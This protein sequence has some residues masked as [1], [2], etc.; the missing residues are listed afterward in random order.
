MSMFEEPAQ[1][2]IAEPQRL[3]KAAARTLVVAKIDES[4]GLAIDRIRPIR[5]VQR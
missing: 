4:T 5:I 1:Q 3:M 2:F